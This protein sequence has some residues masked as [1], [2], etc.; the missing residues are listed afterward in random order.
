MS[1]TDWEPV[2]GLEVHCQLD[3]VSKLFSPCPLQRLAE[4]NTLV[5]PFSLGLPGTLPVVN[6]AAIRSAVALALALGCRVQPRSRFARKHYFYPDLPKGYQTT[7]GTEP[8]AL[9]GSIE[10][11]GD[12]PHRVRLTRIHLEEDAG[13]NVHVPGED[14]SLLDFNRAGAPLLEI[15]SEP[16]LRSGQQAADYLRELRSIVRAL[17]IS[18]ANMEEGT[19]RCDANVSL[20]PRGTDT[21]GTRCEIKNLNSFRFLAQAIAAEIRRQTDVLDSGGAVQMATMSYDPQRDRTRVM[22]TKEDAADYR[23]LPEPDLP[24]LQIEA[25]FIEEIAAGL[26]ELPA[27][28]RRRWAEVGISDADATLLSG[29][30]DLGRYF[31]ATVAAGAPALKA[32]NWVTIELLAKLSADDRTIDACPVSP[33]HLA[34]LIAMVEDGTLSQR[35]AKQVLFAAYDEGLS[36]RQ[37]A[38]R[39]GHQQLSDVTALEAVVAQVL[40][41]SGKQLAQ[42]QGGKVALRGYFVGQVMKKTRGQANPQVVSEILDRRLPPVDADT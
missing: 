12:P 42:Y 24:P 20:R 6:A 4:P 8:Y 33:A 38:E 34:E 32:A 37:I 26:P 18:D 15:V 2:I 16:D 11:P 3:T 21:L 28:Q 35:A 14:V 40:A 30:A 17:G 23:Y 27:Q 36:P 1:A 31:E 9:G 19:L 22:R 10:I 29:D 39:D 5:D 41:A 25:A 7:Q 13:K